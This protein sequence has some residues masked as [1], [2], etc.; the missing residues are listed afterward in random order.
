MR[1][2]TGAICMSVLHIYIYTYKYPCIACIQVNNI[3]MQYA[4]YSD[5]NNFVFGFFCQLSVWKCANL[6]DNI[7]KFTRQKIKNHVVGGPLV[8]HAQ[9]VYCLIRIRNIQKVSLNVLN[10][11]TINYPEPV[12]NCY[13]GKI[14]LDITMF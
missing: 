14:I 9:V 4:P 1:G 11:N 5:K 13:N 8:C 3:I 2:T 6:D 10:Y 12:G 7:F